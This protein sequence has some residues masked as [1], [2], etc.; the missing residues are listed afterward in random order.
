MHRNYLLVFKNILLIKSVVTALFVCSI[1]SDYGLMP[2]RMYTLKL[3][4]I[5]A[6]YN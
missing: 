6:M 2:I 1:C 5:N 4:L 3:F